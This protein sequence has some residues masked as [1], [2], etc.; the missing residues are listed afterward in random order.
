MRNLVV[1][2][3]ITLD[4]VIDMAAGWFDPLNSEVDQSDIHEVLAEQRAAADALLLGR[5]TFEDF[6]EFWPKHSDD[7]AGVSD[8][9][10]QV[11]K[12]VI[13]NAMDDPG[14]ENTTVLRGPLLDEVQT[15]KDR[16][17]G[18]IVV[19]GSIQLV[20]SLITADIVDE[21]RLFVYPVVIGHGA[22]LFESADIRLTLLETRQFR[23]GVVLLRYASA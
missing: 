17:G 14:W 3:N 1:T 8:Y 11:S 15:L 20:Q 13:A 6:R 9:L 23:S 2:E 18:D 16:P 7:P 19:T 5:N 22:R 10:N 12:Y 4:G 21:Y